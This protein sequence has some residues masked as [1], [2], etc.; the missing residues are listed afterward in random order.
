MGKSAK[1]HKRVVSRVECVDFIFTHLL[2][3]K[4]SKP[5]S[6]N[7]SK[8]ASGSSSSSHI[9]VVQ[10]AKKRAKLKGRAISTTASASSDPSKGVLGDADYVS[11]LMGG[12][13]KAKEEALKLPQKPHK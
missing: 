8:L 13:R 3:P 1:V 12:R 11:L 4:K 10:S 5:S 2:Q 9:Q 7:L 6:T